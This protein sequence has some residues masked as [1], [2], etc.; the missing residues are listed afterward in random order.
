[1]S[2]RAKPSP[3]QRDLFHVPVYQS[4]EP[5]QAIACIDFASQ[6]ARDMSRALKQCPYDRH[7]VAMRMA[8]A[9]GQDDFSKATLDAYTSEAKGS[10]QIS[11]VRFKAFVRAT[12]QYWLWDAVVADDGLTMLE[13]DE[14]RLA[15]IARVDQA[16][17]ELAAYKKQLTATPVVI[18]RRAR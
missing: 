16:Q 18:K 13:G 1:M 12:E 6:L 3:D 15:E 2:R 10:H 5:S 9:L 11:L 8:Q 4:R 17:A 7:E 14:A